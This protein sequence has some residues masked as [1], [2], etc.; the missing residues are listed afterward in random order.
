MI[1]L[2]NLVDKPDELRKALETFFQGTLK[3][4][5]MG[6][7]NPLRRDDA[8]GLR[9]LQG[10][11]D[12]FG[13]SRSVVFIECETTP[14]N[15]VGVL[16]EEQPSH[17]LFI[18]AADARLSAGT[19]FLANMDQIKGLS[20]S[21]HA[22]PLNV[23]AEFIETLVEAKILLLGIQPEDVSFGEGLTAGVEQAAGRAAEFL[24]SILTPLAGSR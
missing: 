17:I 11:R 10:V 18:D 4:A 8:V 16:R 21:T 1:A 15:Y 9:V 23:Y 24:S 6:I 22:I 2:L 19:L 3:A 13:P 5:L 20:I 14:E 12:R 7:G